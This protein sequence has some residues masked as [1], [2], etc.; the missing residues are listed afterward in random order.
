M[1]MLTYLDTTISLMK[2]KFFE[3]VA[4]RLETKVQFCP[5]FSQVTQCLSPIY[6]AVFL[7]R[8]ASF[9]H[10]TSNGCTSWSTP[11]TLTLYI[12][13]LS[14]WVWRLLIGATWALVTLISVNFIISQFFVTLKGKLLMFFFSTAHKCPETYIS[15]TLLAL[16]NGR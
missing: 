2:R 12:T 1:S 8:M 14:P 4:K 16:L 9:L 3:Y 7:M 10:S 11:N 13:W 15:S 6:K 5:N